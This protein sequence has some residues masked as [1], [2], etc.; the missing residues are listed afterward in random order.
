[1]KYYLYIKIIK[2]PNHID[3]VVSQE[4]SIDGWIKLAGSRDKAGLEEI[5]KCILAR[6]YD[7]Y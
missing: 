1:M 4:K 5:A 2:S 7:V 3:A 6:N